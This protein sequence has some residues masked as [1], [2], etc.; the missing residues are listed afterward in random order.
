MSKYEVKLGTF[1]G[2][3]RVI[4]EPGTARLTGARATN[5]DRGN[6]LKGYPCFPGVSGRR[7]ATEHREYQP[8]RQRPSSF[9]PP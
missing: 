5:V 6:P 9:E 8:S 7:R 2:C 3:R 1:E 4:D